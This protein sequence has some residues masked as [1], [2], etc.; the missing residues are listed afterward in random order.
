MKHLAAKA[1]QGA[2]D[3]F[4]TKQTRLSGQGIIAEYAQLIELTDAELEAV[5][6]GLYGGS[7]I[8]GEVTD[9]HVQD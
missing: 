7:V 8:N 4:E 5:A 3:T 1:S 9:P 2:G 6:G